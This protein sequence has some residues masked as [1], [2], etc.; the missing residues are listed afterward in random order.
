M[1]APIQTPEPEHRNPYREF[2][3]RFGRNRLAVFGFGVVV[4]FV[5]VSVVF[6]IVGVAEINFPQDPNKT[7]VAEKL[8]APSSGHLLGTDELGRDVF[9]RMLQGAHVS[10]LVGF[11]AVG[12][13]LAIGVVI[14]SL[15]GYFGGKTDMILMRLVDV[16]L[17]FPSFFL[18]L[19]VVALL[20]PSFWNVM[21]VIGLT[22]WPGVSRLV[23]AEFLS[24]KE[25]DFV[26]SV[27]ALGAGTGR[28]IFRHILPNALTPVMVLA[29]LEVA[30]AILT[31]SGLSFLG[32]G[33]QPPQPTW[34][35]I[36]TAGRM[37]VF[38]AWWLT[39]FP[40]LAILTTVL[41]F[42]L[43]G[44]GLRDALDPKLRV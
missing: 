21:I 11:V 2:L 7:A 16:V 39:V 23:R 10:L 19:T 22:S 38:D 4:L 14:G 6:W 25:R 8:L 32:F 42:Y 12:I 36:L 13:A 28:I 35:N 5:V 31:E 26:M 20:E 27:R 15:A 30:G 24:L 43:F 41:S 17:C 40:G 9:S 34:G 37:Y 29:T 18:I 44:E 1:D 33:V 3:R